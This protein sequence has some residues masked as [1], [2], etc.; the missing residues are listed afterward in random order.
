MPGDA[1]RRLTL[2]ARETGA[3][4]VLDADGAALVDGLD[5]EP[6][7]VKPNAGELSAAT[8]RPA[9]TPA[10]ALAAAR[11]LRADRRTAVVASL[12]PAGIVA[13]T[14]AGDFHAAP[15]EALPGNPT[16]AGDAAVAALAAGLARGLSWPELLADAVALSAAAVAAPAAGELD[17]GTAAR[18][19]AAVTVVPFEGE[20]RRAADADR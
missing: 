1:Y 18:V 2:T 7:V 15:P 3:L 19:R 13:H 12:G 10:E 14:A 17:A 5:A 4:V 9:G 8:G 6:D 20:T 11:I 16:G